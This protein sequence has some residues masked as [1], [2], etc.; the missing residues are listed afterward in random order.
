MTFSEI[1]ALAWALDILS[2]K[3]E[4]PVIKERKQKTKTVFDEE[5]AKSWNWKLWLSVVVAF[6]VAFIWLIIA[7]HPL[8]AGIVGGIGLFVIK[9]L[10]FPTK[11]ILEEK[12]E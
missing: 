1:A 2:P 8:F 9:L 7:H 10:P 6:I 11:T 12:E 5:A 3:K 4:P